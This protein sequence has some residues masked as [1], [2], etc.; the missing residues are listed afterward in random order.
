MDIILH[1]KI[2]RLFSKHKLVIKYFTTGI[3]ASFIDLGL[4]FILREY[5]DLWYLYSAVIA[6]SIS[7]SVAFVAQKYWTFRDYSDHNIHGQFFW[8]IF[9]VLFCSGLNIAVLSLLIEIA[10]INHML[11]QI[12]ALAFAGFVGFIMNVR[13]VFHDVPSRGGIVFASGIFPPDI[14][15]PATFVKNL[16]ERLAGKGM[17]VTVVTYADKLEIGV[18]KGLGYDVIRV[19]RYLPFGIRHLVYVFWLF[20]TSI[21]HDLVYAQDVTAAGLPA[22]L[23]KKVLDKRMII[24]IGGDLLWERRAES[25][26]TDLSM[27]DFYNS[28]MHKNSL[29]FVIGK[30]V[31]RN[32]D[33]VFVTAENLREVYVRYYGVDEGRV[34]ILHNPPPDLHL[35]DMSEVKGK[36]EKTVIFAGRL[37]RY[38]NVDKL[39]DIFLEIYNSISPAKLLIIGDGPEYATLKEKIKKVGA[40]RVELVGRL[41][42]ADILNQIRS[43]DLCVSAATTEYNPNF[44]LEAL[45]LHKRVLINEDNGLSVRLPDAFLF[46]DKEDLKNKMREIL[47]EQGNFADQNVNNAGLF[48]GNTLDG[49]TE[50]HL[51]LFKILGVK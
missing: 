7:F 38:K 8:Y 40:G 23:I 4:F 48:T 29:I 44:I 27:R 49:I 30:M 26:R 21:N 45:A 15:G 9:I 32:C 14:G 47:L 12:I 28:G 18:E 6:L 10:D 2:S 1:K 17:D 31:L 13:N 46:K 43:A 5:Y 34:E 51:A 39:I 35:V 24:R 37:I 33:K 16:S 36:E 25:G 20:F 3:S 22:L 11:A 50:K 41:S 42:N 19:S